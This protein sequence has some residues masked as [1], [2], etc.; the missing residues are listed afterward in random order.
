MV[1]RGTNLQ[2]LALV[3]T[4]TL[5]YIYPLT[6][7]TPLIEPDEGLHATISQEML[8]RGDWVLPTFR[9]EPFLDKPILYF[10]AQMV[11]L[12]IFGMTEQAVRLPGLLFGV[13]GAIST[14]ALAA[15]LFDGATGR[16]ACLAALTM[17]I[18]AVL[19]QAAV[20]DVALV[21]F[22]NLAMLA[23]WE[24]EQ[25][26]SRARRCLWLIFAALI[27]GLTIL[28]KGLL[29]PAIVVAGFAGWLLLKKTTSVAVWARLFATVAAG[30]VVASPW[31]IAVEFRVPGYLYYYFVERHILGFATTTQPHGH[32]PWYYY[33]PIIVLGALPWIYFV[34]PLLLDAWRGASRRRTRRSPVVLLLAWLLG[35]LLFLSA[36]RSKLA[37]YALPLFPV[38][39][40]LCAVSWQRF[41]AGRMTSES[42]RLFAWLLRA[43]GLA[44]VLL[45][46]A[47]LAICQRVLPE[48]LPLQCWLF[49]AVVS[50]VSVAA[51]VTFERR[52][53]AQLMNLL[54]LW[55][56]GLMVLS[57]T[58]PLQQFAKRHSEREL[59]AWLNQCDTLPSK[60]ILVGEKPASVIFYLRPEIRT[61][62]RPEQLSGLPV[63]ELPEPEVVAISTVIAITESAV[64]DAMQLNLT[65]PGIQTHSVGQFRLFHNKAAALALA[66][67]DRSTQEQ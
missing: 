56:A 11:S 43:G 60:L 45:P 53:L 41:R 47:G 35:G 64:E 62:L 34:L 16:I 50:A 65:V 36:A 21:P 67:A 61:R 2:L 37:T 39:A 54:P 48:P 5:V 38:I 31:F 13:L 20:H 59:A 30:A 46:F 26:A 49:A 63:A 8:E 44:G 57:M 17:F 29:G 55:V 18:P 6:L 10:W 24:M 7:S 19:A 4:V 14:A 25:S 32:E 28:T 52:Q 33:L 1:R 40:I 22:T 51:I 23:L 66:N 42:E 12:R 58:W 27:F 15:R 9:G 3:A